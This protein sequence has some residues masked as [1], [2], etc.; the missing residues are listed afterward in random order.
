MKTDKIISFNVREDQLDITAFASVLW[1][2]NAYNV[3]IPNRK[4]SFLNIFE[5][6]I[7]GLAALGIR[8]T[9]ELADA[10]CMEKELVSFIQNRLSLLGYLKRKEITD[11]GKAVLSN[12]DSD[13]AAE[14]ASAW[15]F[16][17]LT[18]GELLPYLMFG[19]L[20]YKTVVN[21]YRKEETEFKI[22]K[23]NTTDKNSKK[24]E[25]IRSNKDNWPAPE[26]NGLIRAIKNFRDIHAQYAAFSKNTDS[27]PPIPEDK[28]HI[29]INKTPVPLYLHC[30]AYILRNNN[31]LIVSDGFGFGYSD[32]FASYIKDNQS[33]IITFLRKNAETPTVGA[34]DDDEA[35]EADD[36]DNRKKKAKKP[37][38]RI[39]KLINEAG[40]IYEK[41]KQYQGKGYAADKKAAK[42][43]GIAL[44]KTYS[45]LE[46]AFA[47]VVFEKGDNQWERIYRGNLP[48]TN[49]ETLK[50]YAK[51]IGLTMNDRNISMLRPEY[52]KLRLMNDGKIDM[53]SVL[54]LAI[55]GAFYSGYHPINILAV[56]HPDILTILNDFNNAS[57]PKRHGESE[58]RNLRDDLTKYLE[59]T[60]EIITLLLPD[61]AGQFESRP[62]TTGNQI[63]DAHIER[64]FQD[65]LRAGN[66]LNEYFGFAA[67][68]AIDSDIKELLINLLILERDKRIDFSSFDSGICDLYAALQK[69]YFKVIHSANTSQNDSDSPSDI[70]SKAFEK[71]VR[72]K[73]AKSVQDI[74]G[75]LSG[76]KPEKLT[77]ILQRRTYSLQADFIILLY[78]C[79]DETL[80]ALHKKCPDLLTF[81]A[82][83]ADLRGHDNNDFSE[84]KNMPEKF[85]VL[86]E[87]TFKAIKALMEV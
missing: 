62:E 43:Q 85:K 48:E 22:F 30:M 86:K 31:S 80:E 59:L 65:R 4:N 64:F 63:T 53:H 73:F 52:G 5:E 47:Q 9:E 50:G 51:K 87:E 76:V 45:A 34:D 46:F 79:E 42:E 2:C 11:L 16:M 23:I 20:E 81:T 82:E 78:V 26:T 21:N 37:V 67:M 72:H 44:K 33:D 55:T 71:A 28:T 35:D 75:A 56:K 40:R 66:R 57:K 38:H 14:P 12:K 15:V 83:L 8:E 25:V 24:A 17:D 58:S 18:N 32:P 54:A 10:S 7:L 69:M 6:T 41:T 60:K 74:P 49:K 84:E 39:V 70:K 27:P 19:A 3:I 1:P 13:D 29:T 77:Y 68:K 36:D 61:I